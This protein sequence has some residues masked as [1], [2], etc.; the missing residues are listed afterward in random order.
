MASINFQH[1]MHTHL[2]RSYPVFK[3]L[4]CSRGAELLTRKF[5]RREY[6][7]PAGKRRGGGGG[8]ERNTETASVNICKHDAGTACT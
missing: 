8:G 6:I 2:K 7:Y 4:I 1:N 5:C 3:S